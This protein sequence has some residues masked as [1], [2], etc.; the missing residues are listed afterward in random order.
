M[1]LLSRFGEGVSVRL[2]ATPEL[3]RANYAEICPIASRRI[4]ILCH[5]VKSG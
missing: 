1:S 2:P 4:N 3:M 5:K